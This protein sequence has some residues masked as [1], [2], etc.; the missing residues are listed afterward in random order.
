MG[1]IV[2]TVI[3]PAP[4]RA[5]VSLDVVK[6]ELQIAPSD[7]A[8]DRWFLRVI[9]QV[10]AQIASYC[11]RPLVAE[12][13][14]DQIFPSRDWTSFEVIGGV[15]RLQLSRWPVIAVT[16]VTTTDQNAYV[17]TLVAGTDY[18][19]NLDSGSLVRLGQVTG[20]PSAWCP[21][22]TTVIYQ[23][24][25]A[26]IPS[27][28][29]EVALRMVT[30]RYRSRGRDPLLKVDE[31]RELGRTEYWVPGAPQMRG[32]LREDYAA[33]LDPYRVPVIA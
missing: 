10:S 32:T 29:E 4:S 5:L 13:V 8:N 12:T 24:G 9:D 19:A 27:D 30:D 21:M 2:T 25:Y 18:D 15:G 7:F 14:Q 31:T 17:Q 26:P 16:S 1:A 33:P 3:T 23:G 11:N 22:L 20:Y 6:E 28:I